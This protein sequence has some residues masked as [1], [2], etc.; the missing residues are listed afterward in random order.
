MAWLKHLATK[1]LTLI[2]MPTQRITISGIPGL[3]CCWRRKLER[4]RMC[5]SA[6]KTR[7]IYKNEVPEYLHFRGSPR[8]SPLVVF[9]S[10]GWLISSN[11]GRS[12]TM[13]KNGQWTELAHGFISVA[14]ASRCPLHSLRAGLRSKRILRENLLDPLVLIHCWGKYLEFSL[15]RTTVA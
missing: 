1:W 13:P 7:V 8:F 10:G 11:K 5:I 9:P 15:C 6:L 3:T 4:W 12:V 14:S 2:N